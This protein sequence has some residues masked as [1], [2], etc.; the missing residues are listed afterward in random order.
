MSVILRGRRARYDNIAK[1]SATGRERL[2]SGDTV[3]RLEMYG[4]GYQT[5]TSTGDTERSNV[6]K[7]SSVTDQVSPDTVPENMTVGVAYTD[8]NPGSSNTQGFV[9]N[10]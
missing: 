3:S 5:S 1:G 2:I 6:A 8:E 4:G 9:T 7:G 10:P